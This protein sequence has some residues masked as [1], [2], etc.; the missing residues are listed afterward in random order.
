MVGAASAVRSQY[1][2]PGPAGVAH[3]LNRLSG[4]D[5]LPP[6]CREAGGHMVLR[7]PLTEGC[8]LQ[9]EADWACRARCSGR[10]QGTRFP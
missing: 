9:M 3:C 2:L 4:Q 5:G 6:A 7:R 8:R 1:S 10:D